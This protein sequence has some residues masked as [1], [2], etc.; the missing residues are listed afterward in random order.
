MFAAR[1]D[2]TGGVWAQQTVGVLV[3]KLAGNRYGRLP[4]SEG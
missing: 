1:V 3:E 4:R 2:S